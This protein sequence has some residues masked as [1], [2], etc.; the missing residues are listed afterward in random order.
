MKLTLERCK[1]C[2][3]NLYRD[4]DG[5]VCL[6][7]NRRPAPVGI[8]TPE[9]K[10]TDIGVTK[11]HELSPRKDAPE[12]TKG[13]R[14]GASPRARYK[15]IEGNTEAI[16]QDLHNFGEA[17]T[18][19]KWGMSKSTLRRF[20]MRHLG[21]EQPFTVT[22]TF[23]PNPATPAAPGPALPP[24]PPWDESWSDYLKCAWLDAYARMNGGRQ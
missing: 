14:G 23:I 22:G 15:Y 9:V 20:R 16:K 8:P 4:E 3:G 1:F 6:L 2:E 19:K 7:C 10:M 21:E 17:E 18:M 5:L 11:C 12:L 24:Y 13:K